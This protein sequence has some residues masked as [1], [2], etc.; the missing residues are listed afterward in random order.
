[1]R[2]F[3]RSAHSSSLSVSLSLIS[4]SAFH[5]AQLMLFPQPFKPACL[6]CNLGALL[7]CIWNKTHIPN[8]A[9]LT[10]TRKPCRDINSTVQVNGML[11]EGNKKR[12]GSKFQ[13]AVA[14]CKSAFCFEQQQQHSVLRYICS[15]GEIPALGGISKCLKLSPQLSSDWRPH[16]TK[17][18][19]YRTSC[20]GRYSLYEI[21]AL[22]GLGF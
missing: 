11:C 17:C 4:L 7:P 1:M 19:P 22:F 18:P 2:L 20:R 21:S 10:Y 5:S 13:L 15:S 3:Y 14:G 8:T 6:W 12:A 9:A 16:Q